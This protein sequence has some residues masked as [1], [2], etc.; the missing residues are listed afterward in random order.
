MSLPQNGHSFCKWK[1]TFTCIWHMPWRQFHPGWLEMKTLWTN[2]RWWWKEKSKDSPELMISSPNQNDIKSFSYYRECEE[3]RSKTIS[4][5]T[6]A[7]C[8]MDDVWKGRQFFFIVFLSISITIMDG[9]QPDGWMMMMTFWEFSCVPV[10]HPSTTLS[11]NGFS[12][13]GCTSAC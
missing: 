6:R 12:K 8:R 11:H 5:V 4:G 13:D 9:P 10:F 2:K 7:P 3:D 1:G